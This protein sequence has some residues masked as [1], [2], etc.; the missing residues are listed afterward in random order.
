MQKERVNLVLE[1][2]LPAFLA[3]DSRFNPVRVSTKICKSKRACGILPSPFGFLVSPR[4]DPHEVKSRSRPSP[5]LQHRVLN[6]SVLP[7]R[8]VLKGSTGS[9][10][11]ALTMSDNQGSTQRTTPTRTSR[12]VPDQTCY[13]HR[14]FCVTPLSS[15]LRIS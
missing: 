11:R 2:S 5:H 14:T 6:S 15:P 9:S 3:F 13:L 7:I 1:S 4:G 10:G 12:A 8:C